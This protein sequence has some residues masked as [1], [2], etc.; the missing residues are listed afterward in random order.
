MW[1]EAG[2]DKTKAVIALCTSEGLRVHGLYGPHWFLYDDISALHSGEEITT[3]AVSKAR[4]HLHPATQG[5]LIDRI[6]HSDEVEEMALRKEGE[7]EFYV[8]L[9]FMGDRDVLKLDGKDVGTL[10]C[11]ALLEVMNLEMVNKSGAPSL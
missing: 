7:N 6:L 4:L 10:L 2:E 3:Y 11:C 1:I 5:L 8:T 9:W